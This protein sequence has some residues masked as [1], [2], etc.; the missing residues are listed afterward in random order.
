MRLADATQPLPT[1]VV[2]SSEAATPIS[3][4]GL[5]VEGQEVLRA[6]WTPSAMATT[7][8]ARSRPQAMAALSVG[9][10]AVIHA[11]LSAPSPAVASCTLQPRPHGVCVVKARF[12]SATDLRC[13][14]ECQADAPKL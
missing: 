3:V 13:D 14:F 1:G 12:V 10:P 7:D 8:A 4:A 2:L 9:R 6:G 5:Q 11:T